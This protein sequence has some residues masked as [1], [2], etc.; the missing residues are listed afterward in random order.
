MQ[1][2]LSI[3]SLQIEGGLTKNMAQTSGALMCAKMLRERIHTPWEKIR[4]LFDMSVKT[5]DDF[6]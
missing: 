4:S 1:P 5:L 3:L 2:L 6:Q